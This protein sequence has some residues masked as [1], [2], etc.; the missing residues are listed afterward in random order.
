MD[1][2]LATFGDITRGKWPTRFEPASSTVFSYLMNNYWATNYAAAQ[3]GTFHFR[4]VI[5]SSAHLDPAS[6]FQL[7]WDSMQPALVNHVILQDKLSNPDRPLPAEGGSFLKVS[8]P[9]VALVAWKLRENGEGTVLRLQEL[10]GEETKTTLELPG[11]NIESAHLCSA[12]ED[13]L[14]SLR[15]Q[16]GM[17]Q[18]TLK[19]NEVQTICLP[20]YNR[21]W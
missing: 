2:P 15:V 20:P 16:G 4:Y 7:G 3:G 1:A 13:E 19:P 5:T 8:A 6:L 17:I 21:L 14:Q 11:S 12:A 9:N 10:A 18:L